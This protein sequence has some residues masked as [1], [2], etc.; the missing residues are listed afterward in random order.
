MRT[1]DASHEL[2]APMTLIYTA[3]QSALR[4]ERSPDQLKESLHKGLRGA[5][6][7]TELINQLLWLARSDAGNI[8]MELVS[9]DVAALVR[10]VVNEVTMLADNKELK[11]SA[12]LAEAPVHALVDEASLR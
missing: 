2:R 8:R 9:T 11:L 10:E 7:C 5:K 1:A 3:A 4:R 12:S 6:R